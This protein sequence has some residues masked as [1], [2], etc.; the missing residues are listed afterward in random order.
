VPV[1]AS[2]TVPQSH[3]TSCGGCA[4][5][6][7]ASLLRDLVSAMATEGDGLL[8]HMTAGPAMVSLR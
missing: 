8:G 2:Q 5:K 4:A 6:W 7:D 1:E 3:L